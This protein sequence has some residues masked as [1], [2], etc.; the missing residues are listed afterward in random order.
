MITQYINNC[1]IRILANHDRQP[2][3][4]PFR[5]TES[6]NNFNAITHIDIWFPYRNVMFL[7]TI[8]KFSKYATIHKLTDGF[9]S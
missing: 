9:Q 8:D 4:V 5:L 3:K 2:V 7:T 6:A 1:E